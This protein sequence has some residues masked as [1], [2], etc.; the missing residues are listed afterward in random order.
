M[1][2]VEFMYVMLSFILV[3]GAVVLFMWYSVP[4]NKAYLL[5]TVK[6]KNYCVVNIRHGGGQIR[7]HV[8]CTEA[9][10]GEDKHPTFTIKDREYIPIEKVTRVEKVM[11]KDGS[12]IDRE[13]TDTIV[14][15]TSRGVPVYYYNYDDAK[16]VAL[17]GVDV[18]QKF[19][20]PALLN[21]IFMQVLALYRTKV[22]KE[23]AQLMKTVG[24]WDI[25]IWAILG[26]SVV[27]LLVGLYNLIQLQQVQSLVVNSHNILNN[28][29]AT[30]L[31]NSFPR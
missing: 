3:V 24:S 12:V 26:I 31:T 6:K 10:K 30:S 21:S 18:E 27:A 8:V 28:T 2:L 9:N 1:D 19:R 17:S 13:V 20:N 7:P 5:R 4:E 14:N 22:A 23:I 15:F 16:P 25:R 29:I 11:R